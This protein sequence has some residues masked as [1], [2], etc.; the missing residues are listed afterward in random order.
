M[1][2]E[3]PAGGKLPRVQAS[4]DGPQGRGEGIRLVTGGLPTAGMRDHGVLEDPAPRHL[5]LWG[6]GPRP[7]MPAPHRQIIPREPAH[8]A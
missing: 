7:G 6:F 2:N 3:G 1:D 5:R 4:R 8:A